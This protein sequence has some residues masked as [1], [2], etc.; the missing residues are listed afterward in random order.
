MLGTHSR[1]M[2]INQLHFKISINRE[3][4]ERMKHY[5]RQWLLR[6][7]SGATLTGFGISYITEVSL[8]RFSGALFF[9]W[10]WQGT[11]AL[12]IFIAG[13]CLIVDAVRF[14]IKLEDQEP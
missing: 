7:G 1:I 11:L 2:L 6:G 8:M 9:D 3:R 13:I 5:K 12:G 4:K 14:K 10:F